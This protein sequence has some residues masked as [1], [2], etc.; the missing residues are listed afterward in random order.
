MGC[1]GSCGVLV[2]RVVCISWALL[3]SLEDEWLLKCAIPRA[4]TVLTFITYA[5]I[6]S[7]AVRGVFPVWVSVLGRREGW[8]WGREWG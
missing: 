2:V 7:M 5:L 3:S 6:V 8:G 1:K 4:M